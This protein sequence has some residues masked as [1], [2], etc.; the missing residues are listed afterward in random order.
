MSA[1]FT[2]NSPKFACHITSNHAGAACRNRHAGRRP[3]TVVRN[4]RGQRSNRASQRGVAL[5]VALILL[6]V[7]TL[8]GLAAVRGTILQ[9]KMASNMLDRQVA[10]QNAEAAMRVAATTIGTAPANIA[11]NCQAASAVCLANP[12]E[13]TGLP[14]GSIHTVTTSQYSKGA[15]AMSQPQFVIENMGSF[16]NPDT[17]TG[18]GQ[19]ANSKQYGSSAAPPSSIYYRV[20]VRSGD[21]ALVGDRAVVTLQAMIK[22]G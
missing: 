12:F 7:I 3:A 4:P 9:Q 17:N 2:P 22:Q 21:P 19:S 15:L 11:R 14:G 1:D 20:T 6:L 16:A 5:V 18:Y 10:F 13:D 8:V